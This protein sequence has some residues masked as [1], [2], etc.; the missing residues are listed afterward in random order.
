MREELG[1]ALTALNRKSCVGFGDLLHK[2]FVLQQQVQ[3]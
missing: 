2:N 3:V 1:A